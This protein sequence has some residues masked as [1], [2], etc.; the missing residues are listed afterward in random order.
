MNPQG[1]QIDPTKLDTDMF[2]CQNSHPAMNFHYRNPLP[3]DLY[4]YHFKINVNIML[5]RIVVIRVL[6]MIKHTPV[7]MM[8]VTWGHVLDY[9]CVSIPLLVKVLCHYS[10]LNDKIYMVHIYI[11]MDNIYNPQNL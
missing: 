3:K 8:W 9:Q 2:V 6:C 11:E 7:R 10:T 1:P 4:H 5:E